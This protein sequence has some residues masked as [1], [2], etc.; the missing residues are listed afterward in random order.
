MTQAY[1]LFTAATSS[2]DANASMDVRA[3]GNIKHVA[4]I[5]NLVSD[6][7]SNEGIVWELSFGATRVPTTNDVQQTIMTMPLHTFATTSGPTHAEANVVVHDVDIP[8]QAG[9]RIF[10][11]TL[12]TGTPSIANCYVYL[13]IEE[14]GGSQRPSVRRGR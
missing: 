14:K 10:L 4:M 13:F 6:S 8:V 1:R 12:A 7:L 2:G 9:E 3:D 11:H 5:G